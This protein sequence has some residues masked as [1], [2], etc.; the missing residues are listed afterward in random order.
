ML[1]NVSIN[2]SDKI[3]RFDD[4][5]IHVDWL[6]TLSDSTLTI[7][8]AHNNVYNYN[9]SKENFVNTTCKEICLLYPFK[10][11]LLLLISLHIISYSLSIND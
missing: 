10:F 11:K 4:W 8:F 7:L 2:M 3:H 1:F 6:G 9:L 5:I